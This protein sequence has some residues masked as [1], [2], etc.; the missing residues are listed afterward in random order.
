MTVVQDSTVRSFPPEPVSA[1]D[2]RRF[3][4]SFLLERGRDELVD[5]AAMALSEV[6]TNAVLHAHTDFEV[7]AALLGDGSLRVEVTDRSPQLPAQR[8]YGE[9]ATTGRGMQLVAAMTVDCGVLLDGAS[10]KT[11]WFLVQDVPDEQ[12]PGRAVGR[13]AGGAGADGRGGPG[14]AARAPADAVARDAPAPRR[15]PA[16]AGPVRAGA[17]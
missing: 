4:R 10:G 12:A 16:R 9:Q 13:R 2:A 3:L 1:R 15:R 8:R 17:P 14:A 11:V 5:A 7:S 6:V